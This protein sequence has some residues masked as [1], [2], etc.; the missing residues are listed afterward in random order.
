[1]N[2]IQALKDALMT[3]ALSAVLFIPA[4]GMVLKERSLELKLERSLALVAVVFAGRLLLTLARQA[5]LFDGLKA[6][7]APLGSGI[8]RGVG[9][10]ERH[11]RWLLLF[12]VLLLALLPFAPFSSNYLLQ[13]FSLTLIYV[14]LASGLNIVVG[15]A[16]LLDLGF[17]AFYAVGAYSYALLAQNV[18]LSFWMAFPIAAALAALAGTILGFPVLRMHGDYLAIVTLGFGEIIRILLVNMTEITG[19]PNGISAPRPSFFGLHFVRRAK[20]G[21]VP[22]H[23][24]FGLEYSPAHRYIYVYLVALAFTI[25]GIFIF[26]RLREMPIGRAW[27]ALREDETACKA[28]GINHTTTKLSAF[29]LGAAYGGVGGVLYAAMEGFINPHSF[30]FLE[31][32]IIL[33]IVVLGG[34]GSIPGVII[35]AVCITLL[36]ELF[37][38]FEQYRMLIFGLAIVVIMVWRPGGLLK[39]RRKSFSRGE[40][41]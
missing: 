16:G 5:G 29:T 34:M 30:T 35:A 37:R 36:P 19:G 9:N 3:A 39:V 20:E 4:V 38:E 21:V 6:R 28:L 24:F 8:A 22:F 10:L 31:S 13:I 41:L 40:A 15:L 18:G 12:L 14:L 32:A 1:M 7:M 11:N 23:E 25:G 27:E 2:F 17:V 26:K 33:A